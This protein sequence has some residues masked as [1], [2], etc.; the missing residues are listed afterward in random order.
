MSPLLFFI[1]AMA[2]A[3]VKGA[4]ALVFTVGQKASEG[5]ARTVIASDQRNNLTIRFETGCPWLWFVIYARCV[6]DNF[7][8]GGALAVVRLVD[9]RGE[10]SFRSHDTGLDGAFHD[11]CHFRPFGLDWQVVT[12]PKSWNDTARLE[13][14]R[15]PACRDDNL[16]I[17]VDDF[18]FH[19]ATC[20]DDL[21]DFSQRFMVAASTLLA[22][23]LS[24]LLIKF[25]IVLSQ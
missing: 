19:P 23:V 6:K 21:T 12:S 18:T 22:I 4:P 14:S 16:T 13:L 7:P 1:F 10:T 5:L 15:G 25:L 3:A 17:H 2:V 8:H 20:W 11:T 9:S 24:A